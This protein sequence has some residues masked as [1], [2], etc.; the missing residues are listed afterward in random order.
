MRRLLCCAQFYFSLSLSLV[1][2]LSGEIYD[3]TLFCL[4]DQRGQKLIE[5]DLGRIV[6]MVNLE[7]S[8]LF[9]TVRWQ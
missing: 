1:L 7:I 3:P 2:I 9:R 4:A 5:I 8:G 6:I